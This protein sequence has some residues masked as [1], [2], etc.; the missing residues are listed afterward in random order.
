MRKYVAE[1]EFY[2]EEI[3]ECIRTW[4]E[5]NYTPNGWNNVMM[6][7]HDPK[8]RLIDLLYRSAVNG[9]DISDWESS[10]KMTRASV[11]VR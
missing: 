3:Q 9:H 11:I 2:S 5:F 7:L 10:F 6:W 4:E 8:M 1:M